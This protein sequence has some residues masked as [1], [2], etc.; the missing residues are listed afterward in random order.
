M[1]RRLIMAAE[2]VVVLLSLW[3]LTK[4]FNLMDQPSDD[5]LVAGIGIIIAIIVL[6]PTV[7]LWLRDRLHKPID[8]PDVT[9]AGNGNVV[10]IHTGETKTT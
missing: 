10:E 2:V 6:A 4:A 1:M 5:K 3:G 8:A 7:I 9:V